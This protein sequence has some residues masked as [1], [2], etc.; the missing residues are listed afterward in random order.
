MPGT[1]ARGSKFQD[2][3]SRDGSE[4]GR[5]QNGAGQQGSKPGRQTEKHWRVLHNKVKN[6]LAENECDAVT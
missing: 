6:N 5:V 2:N 3:R 1:E 4:E